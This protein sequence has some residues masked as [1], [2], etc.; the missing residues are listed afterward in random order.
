M[1]EDEI[2][3]K[4]VE[5]ATVMSKSFKGPY[6]QTEDVL[7]EL[8]GWIMRVGHPFCA[9]PRAVY[10]DDPEQVPEDELRAEVCLPV[11]EDVRGDDDVEYKELPETEVAYK[12]HEGSY[13]GIPAVYEELFEWIEENGYSFKEELGTRE[14]FHKLYG[15]AETEDQLVTE[16]QV[17]VE[18]A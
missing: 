9:P 16:V 13:D 1:A 12:L 8:M 2:Q 18:K 6:D 15:E 10:Y 11:A 14:I 3:T 5:P 4:Q 7:D 17:P